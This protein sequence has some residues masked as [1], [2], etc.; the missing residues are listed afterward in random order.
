M[1]LSAAHLF[2]PLGTGKEFENLIKCFPRQQCGKC[3]NRDSEELVKLGTKDLSEKFIS[4]RCG[5][6]G[7]VI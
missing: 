6:S 2:H 1:F 5:L 4:D 7:Q 3:Q